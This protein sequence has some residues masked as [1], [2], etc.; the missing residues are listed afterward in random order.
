MQI[1]LISYNASEETRTMHIKSHNIQNMM[2]NE[3]DE[4]IE[5]FLNLSYKII[6]NI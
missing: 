4:I 5:N 6:I 3:P 1:N 2:G